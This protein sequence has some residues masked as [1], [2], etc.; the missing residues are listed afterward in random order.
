MLCPSDTP[1]GEVSMNIELQ[2]FP[3]KHEHGFGKLCFVVVIL[4]APDGEPTKVKYNYIY[5]NAITFGQM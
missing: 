2:L 5:P 1:E 4:L 3:T